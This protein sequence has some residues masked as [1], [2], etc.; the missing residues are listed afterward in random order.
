[1]SAFGDDDPRTDVYDFLRDI[2]QRYD[3]RNS[4]VIAVALEAVSMFATEAADSR[5]EAQDRT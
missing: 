4:R 1:M 5:D 2:Q 3:M